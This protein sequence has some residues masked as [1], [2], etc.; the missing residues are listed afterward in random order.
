LR[1]RTASRRLSFCECL[2]VICI[3]YAAVLWRCFDGPARLGRPLTTLLAL[4]IV[5]AICLVGYLSYRKLSRQKAKNN[6]PPLV[7]AQSQRLVVVAGVGAMAIIGVERVF[8]LVGLIDYGW[9]S[10][11]GALVCGALLLAGGVFSRIQTRKW[12][13]VAHDCDYEL[14]PDCGY[15]LHELPAKHVCPE[16]G[17]GYEIDAVRAAWLNTFD[18]PRHLPE[19]R[20]WTARLRNRLRR[21]W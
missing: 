18:K 20:S 11:L 9:N 12:R 8:R 5:G 15:W 4:C 19:R 2:S 17:R 6:G 21:L 14:C 16:C 10:L 1:K 7:Y 3:V 13:R